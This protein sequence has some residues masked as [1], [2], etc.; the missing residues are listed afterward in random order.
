MRSIQFWR[1][2]SRRSA[3]PTST[4]GPRG[5]E[6]ATAE[7]AAAEVGPASLTS[8]T[9]ILKRRGETTR[10]AHPSAG[11]LLIADGLARPE[12]TGALA[13][14][15]GQPAVTDAEWRQTRKVKRRV[16]TSVSAGARRIDRQ[17]P[18]VP[19]RGE[20]DPPGSARHSQLRLG[21]LPGSRIY[22]M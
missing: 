5:V 18:Q 7:A 20:A 11:Q 12:A 2:R 16:A 19:H 17:D 6:E 14:L 4:L 21:T 1:F 3:R 9:D 13:V 15:C 22:W 10:S 8:L